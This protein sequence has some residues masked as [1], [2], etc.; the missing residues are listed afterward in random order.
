MVS[1]EDFSQ[2]S[3]SGRIISACVSASLDIPR[4]M[5]CTNH[6]TTATMS[7]NGKR[8]MPYTNHP[9]TG[10]LSTNRRRSMHC[11]NHPTTGTT[12]TN[13]PTQNSTLGSLTPHVQLFSAPPEDWSG[14]GQSRGVCHC[15]GGG[16]CSS[17]CRWQR[18]TLAMPLTAPLL[19]PSPAERPWCWPLTAQRSSHW[20]TDT[21][22]CLSNSLRSCNAM[23][24]LPPP[25]EKKNH[26]K[27]FSELT[28]W[29]YKVQ[30]VSLSL[31]TS[32]SAGRQISCL[33]YLKYC[34]LKNKFFFFNFFWF[35]FF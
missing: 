30:S 5:P 13:R 24:S 15:W 8:S 11:T 19:A 23:L 7:T 3:F 14:Q 22:R 29:V 10:T 18:C 17:R 31:K 1:D 16:C 33:G 34:Q 2:V 4:S 26:K 35:F 28:V 12:S 20:E 32:C 25:A 9:T 21:C 6:P 27:I